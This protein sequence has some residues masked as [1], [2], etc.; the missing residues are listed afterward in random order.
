MKFVVYATYD[1]HPNLRETWSYYDSRA[2][3]DADAA[4]LTARDAAMGVEGRR[5]HSANRAMSAL[6][7]LIM[8]DRNTL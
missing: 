3:A 4:R 8:S 6:A 2:H 5:W 7:D 1:T